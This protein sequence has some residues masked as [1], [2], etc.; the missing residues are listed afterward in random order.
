MPPGGSSIAPRPSADDARAGRAAGS[1]QDAADGEVRQE[2]IQA[3]PR[4][5]A[6]ERAPYAEIVGDHQLVGVD[7]RDRD[8]VLAGPDD[9]V[10]LVGGQ[11]LPS[12]SAIVGAEQLPSEAVRSGRGLPGATITLRAGIREAGGRSRPRAAADRRATR[13]VSRFRNRRSGRSCRSGCGRAGADPP[14]R[15]PDLIDGAG[16]R[17]GEREID[18]RAAYFPP[19]RRGLRAKRPLR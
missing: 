13:R 11:I 6:I 16:G 4:K 18:G 7:G 2:L 14:A 9:R 17:R 5:S 8:A 1:G 3:V 10:R 19:V 15:K 12:A